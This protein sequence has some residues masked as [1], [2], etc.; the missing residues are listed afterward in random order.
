MD[1]NEGLLDNIQALA[2]QAKAGVTNFLQQKSPLSE[3]E[4]AA[5]AKRIAEL[6]A[7][8]GDRKRAWIF[9]ADPTNRHYN[10]RH[11]SLTY[12]DDIQRSIKVVQQEYPEVMHRLGVNT[13]Q[14]VIQA[15]QIPVPADLLTLPP[16]L[17][18]H[19]P[20]FDKIFVADTTG[21]KIAGN[22]AYEYPNHLLREAITRYCQEN[23]AG[24]INGTVTP[25]MLQESIVDGIRS[26]FGQGSGLQN[27]ADSLRQTAGQAV[28]RVKQA[29]QAVAQQAGDVYTRV[30]N[31]YTV[32]AAGGELRKLADKRSQAEAAFNQKLEAY[33]ADISQ[34]QLERRELR[35]EQKTIRRAFHRQ[36]HD[37]YVRAAGALGIRV[38]RSYAFYDEVDLALEQRGLVPQ[39]SLS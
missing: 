10:A 19:K 25:E 23:K 6:L 30:R 21:P 38:T 7:N 15:L 35:V 17:A 5:Y 16:H 24:I 1:I 31:D 32:G 13:P 4:K 27:A 29:G 12:L 9:T 34:L 14:E 26:V 11:A 22:D 2:S 18:A 33:K 37:Q 3:V 20:L 36:Q 39:V 8:I 28:D